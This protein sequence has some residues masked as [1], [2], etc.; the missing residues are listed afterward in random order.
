MADAATW[1]DDARRGEGTGKWHFMDIPR[2]QT[3]G[4]PMK[5]CEPVG[6]PNPAEHGD[7]PGCVLTAIAYNLKMVADESAAAGD[8]AKA[9]R[10]VIHFIGD[11]HMPLHTT[12]NK[13]NGG[14]CTDMVLLDS[15]TISNLHSIWDSGIL[16]YH[17]KAGKA[18]PASYADSLNKRFATRK[19]SWSST[20]GDINDWIWGSHT[21]ANQVTYGA[22]Q[23]PIP[24]EPE[25]SKSDCNAETLKVYKLGIRLGDEYAGKA[26][27]VIDEQIA[28]AGF[29]VA[30]TLNQI[31][32]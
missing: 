8:R 3:K 17:L 10:Y 18:S 28:K 16:E 32:P 23:P 1:P 13:D 22:L 31:W 12:D 25:Q 15:T 4:D 19:E 20:A 14:N 30:A 21:A 24:V 27:P 2:Q 6:P 11:L 5:W 9:L 7:R 26:I 29:R